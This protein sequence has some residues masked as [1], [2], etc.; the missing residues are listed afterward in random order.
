[1]AQRHNAKGHKKEWLDPMIFEGSC[2]APL[3]ETWIE[4]CLMEELHEPTIIVMDN[5]SFQNHKRI[6][7][8]GPMGTSVPLSAKTSSKIYGKGARPFYI[9]QSD[10]FYYGNSCYFIIL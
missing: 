1:M 4:Q 7:D 2:T 9:A 3:V 10:D 6:Q 8:I 5:A